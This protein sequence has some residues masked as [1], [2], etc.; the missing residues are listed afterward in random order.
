V[1]SKCSISIFAVPIIIR[2]T[3]NERKRRNQ[4]LSLRFPKFL[5]A[6]VLHG[7]IIG[8]N[9]NMQISTRSRRSGGLGDNPFGV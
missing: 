8:D 3:K 1:N 9:S 2:D 7:W 5:L 4:K 6:L